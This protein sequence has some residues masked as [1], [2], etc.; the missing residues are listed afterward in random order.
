MS[1]ATPADV[2]VEL[3]RSASSATETAQW[4]AWLDR[5]E[6]AIARRF[7]QATLT[8]ADQIALDDPTL[9]DVIDVEVAAVIR[10]IQNPAWGRTSVTRSVDDASITERN[11]GDESDPLLLVDDEWFALLPGY[12]Y[13]G[14]FSTRP[15]FEA[16]TSD[17]VDLWT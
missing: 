9:Q 7:T 17:P 6:R 11:E 5:V 15:G 1:Y 14:A 10:K 16:D 4:Q 12:S 13:S 8:L 2:E 3:G